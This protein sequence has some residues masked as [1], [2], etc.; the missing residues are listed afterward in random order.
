MTIDQRLIANG[1]MFTEVD[2]VAA[3][4]TTGIL[5]ATASTTTFT[6]LASNVAYYRY[7]DYGASYFSTDYYI[8]GTLTVNSFTGTAMKLNF[9]GVFDG[10]GDDT[11]VANGLSMRFGAASGSTWDIYAV[12][13]VS[14]ANTNSTAI[15]GLALNTAYRY[16]AGRY[17]GLGGQYGMWLVQ[18]FNGTTLV[19]HRSHTLT[20]ASAFRYMYSVQ[21]YAFTNA[22]TMTGS[23]ADITVGTPAT[24][25]S[26]SGASVADPNSRFTRYANIA[27]V[28]AL[29]GNENAY[30]YD[31]TRAAGYFT[32]NLN[33]S[34]LLNVTAY[35]TAAT[36]KV[37]LN[38]FVN[39]LEHGNT[40]SNRL[41]I[42]LEQTGATTY[43]LKAEEESGATQYLTAA[44]SSLNFSQPYWIDFVRDNTVGT[45]G[46]L[47]VRIY[48][49]E[50]RQ[51]QVGTTLSLTLH[52]V[53]DFQYFLP[54]QSHN[55]G[56]TATLTFTV[57]EVV[58][59]AIVASG[60]FSGT[61]VA[62]GSFSGLVES[63]SI[64]AGDSVAT[65]AF[66]GASVA[67]APMAGDAVA[68]GSFVGVLLS[69]G[70]AI[71]VGDAVATGA[72][73][74]ASVWSAA[75][76]GTAVA[77]GNF[78][79]AA[80]AGTAYET[81]ISCRIMK[82]NATTGIEEPA[83]S[84]LVPPK[85]SLIR[86]TDKL[87][88]DF[89]DGAFKAPESCALREAA[90]T[91]IS[92]T[93]KPGLFEYTLSTYGLGAGVPTRYMYCI[94]AQID[95]RNAYYNEGDL[96]FLDGVEVFGGMTV[97]QA[98]QL[99]AI[100]T[101]PLLTND[102]RL[103][104]LDAAISSRLAASGY[105]APDNAGIA[106]I[107]GYTDS[108]ES[109]LPAALVG[110]KMDS[111][112]TIAGVPTAVEIA[113]AVGARS[114]SGAL[115]ADQCMRVWAA[116]LHGKVRGAGTGYEIFRDP[117]DTKDVCSMTVDT[118][119]NRSVVVIDAT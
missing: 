80:T 111:V 25:M 44:S 14:S 16:V 90:M 115:S 76:S 4:D 64:F 54:V 5:T 19:G 114:V 68:T 24:G 65:G 108:I 56:G 119:G 21:S 110:G 33:S 7:A 55:N 106:T 79:G 99:S 12:K 74:G 67:V 84:F 70:S 30:I 49:D 60:T 75:F 61:A 118:Q 11:A 91:A 82:T 3:S 36:N 39:T 92:A 20:A 48:A 88:R 42:F 22:D 62:T 72:F 27:L 117:A 93:Y 66:V 10:I 113:A 81:L 69:A 13:R 9:I 100:P 47:Y 116:I 46:T 87:F 59:P 78:T 6:G 29:A 94:E 101:N 109:R 96:V 98:T 43:T 107:A 45:Y 15:T 40:T 86:L 18:V 71:M 102:S 52:A 31:G 37:H 38:S 95:D 53:V 85:V 41:S 73:T 34:I 23:N 105:T 50:R 103:N 83:T 8:D 17:S 1:G 2:S 57:G 77:T 26:L 32:G 35:G 28:A 63:V 104:N 112:A 89:G 97:G 51:V 58:E